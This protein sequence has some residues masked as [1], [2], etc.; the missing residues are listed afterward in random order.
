M[1][2]LGAAV[3]EQDRNN[4]YAV[5]KQMD[6]TASSVNAKFVINTGDAFYWCG[7]QNTSDFQ[8]KTDYLEPFAAQSMQIKWYGALGVSIFYDPF[9]IQHLNLTSY[10]TEPRVRLQRGCSD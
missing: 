5:A 4:E 7:I 3:D 1:T 8:I 6:I 2:F 10:L 9:R